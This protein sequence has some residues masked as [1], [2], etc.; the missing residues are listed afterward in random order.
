MRGISLTGDEIRQKVIN[1][2]MG[3]TDQRHLQAAGLLDNVSP[4][5]PSR[6]NIQTP[7]EQ[8]QDAVRQAQALAQGVAGT[9]WSG[10]FPEEDPRNEWEW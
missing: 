2:R 6:T 3:Q 8:A 7:Q 10:P 4:Y 9:R 1:I 5:P